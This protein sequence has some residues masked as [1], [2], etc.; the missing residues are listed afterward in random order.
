MNEEFNFLKNGPKLDLSP[1]AIRNRDIVNLIQQIC[2]T[3]QSS[4]TSRKQMLI[5]A[6]Y[7]LIIWESIKHVHRPLA[8]LRQNTINSY[9]L[10][11]CL[12][13]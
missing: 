9:V 11:K 1:L 7:D 4:L 3:R 10:T 8:K 12:S 2:S 13:I 6:M 5:K